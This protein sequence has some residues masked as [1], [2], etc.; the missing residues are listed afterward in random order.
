VIFG[1]ERKG[2][3][4]TFPF[5]MG[6]PERRTVGR[7]AEAAPI[8]IAGVVLSHPANK[9]T[10]SIGFALILSS[11]S[12][13]I[14]FLKLRIR[15]SKKCERRRGKRKEKKKGEI[16]ALLVLPVYKITLLELYKEV[17]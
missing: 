7:S 16:N 9:T 1:R 15:S 10:P 8:N 13:D 2:E 17:L 5:S 11:T 3:R 4:I 12:I 6:P 14:K